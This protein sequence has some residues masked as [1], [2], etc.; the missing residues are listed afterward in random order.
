MVHDEDLGRVITLDGI[1]T[2]VVEHDALTL[3]QHVVAPG[4]EA[5]LVVTLRAEFT[6]VGP[7]RSTVRIEQGPF[8]P[9]MLERTR[10]QWESSFHKLDTLLGALYP[11]R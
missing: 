4:S 2:E 8:E 6:D 9:E 10:A 7:G 3:M 1:Y 11:A 5:P